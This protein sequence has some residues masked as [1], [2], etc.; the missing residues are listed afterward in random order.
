MNFY[1]WSGLVSFVANVS[2]GLFVYSRN[3]AENKNKIFGLF[4]LLVSGWSVGSFLV[5]II[6]DAVQALWILR[7]NYLCGVW[8]PSVYVHLAHSL[9]QDTSSKRLKRWIFYAV[10]VLFSILVFTP[11]MIAGLKPVSASSFLITKP[12]FAYYF[13]FGFFATATVEVIFQ[14]FRGI[15]GKIGLERKQFQYLAAANQMSDVI[16][17]FNH[18]ARKMDTK[19]AEGGRASLEKVLENVLE[20]I[21]VVKGPKSIAINKNFAPGLPEV[22]IHESEMEEILLNLLTNAVQAIDKEGRIDI[23]AKK[24]GER[25]QFIIEDTGIGISEKQ[26]SK[27]FEPFHTT[28]GQA[29]TGLGLY[30]TKQILDRRGGTIKVKRRESTGTTFTLEFQGN[31]MPMRGL[32]NIG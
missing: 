25:I 4:S 29:G 12:G 2:I 5:N 27:I 15:V 18:L 19:K 14:I 24:V 7:L 10:S 21:W 28:K 17:R 32:P 13:F 23:A 11:W 30:I 16:G 6:P 1:I 22:L 26:M 3:L 9:N 20:M 31:P 8:V